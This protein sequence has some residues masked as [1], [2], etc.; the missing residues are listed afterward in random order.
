MMLTNTGSKSCGTMRTSTA[1]NSV[2][3]AKPA[4][5]GNKRMCSTPTRAANYGS[6]AKSKDGKALIGFRWDAT[7]QRWVTDKRVNAKVWDDVP[8]MK[9]L[10]GTEYVIWPVIHSTLVQKRLE[11]VD[12]TEAERLVASGKAVFVDVR[13]EYEFEQQHLPGAINIP[14]YQAMEATGFY[15]DL[16]RFVMATAFAMTATERNIEFGAEA[17]QGLP[18][19]KKLIVYCGL[20]GTL[21]VGV[22]TRRGTFDDP[23]R[24]F[25]RE[26]RSL[27]GAY[28]LYEAGFKNVLHLEG[29]ISSWRFSKRPLEGTKKNK[30]NLLG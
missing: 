15:A 26:S 18:K 6:P 3:R 7:L 21:K 16:K 25:G 4:R 12:C 13:P 8:K 22:K 1:C 17:K 28:E 20:G 5:A 29:G 10:S 27:K 30:G 9:Q 14:L 19:G 11:T 23:D 24:S 2:F